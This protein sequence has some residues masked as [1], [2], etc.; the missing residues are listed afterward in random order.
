M[1]IVG[2]C[3]GS[4]SGKTHLLRA[5]KRHFS[6]NQ[7]SL[8]SLD[9]YYKPIAEQ[10]LEP[11]G[12]INFDHP[13]S[14]DLEK[15]A[16]DVNRL[17]NGESFSLQEYT[18]NNHEITPKTFH[19]SPTPI[20][21]V[22]G[23]LVFYHKPLADLMN[24]KIFV[25]ADEHIRLVRRLRRDLKHRNYSYDDTLHDYEHF[26]APMYKQF[27]EPTKYGCD[28]IIMNNH[29]MQAAIEV[30]TNHLDCIHAKHKN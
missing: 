24:L 17:I 7:M 20:I 21:I 18:F 10:K 9:N 26:V 19:Y 11:N 4:A 28:M 29:K 15:C 13:Q 22:E 2:I 27:V 30:I 5:L 12:R 6:G 14:L 3:G 25:E 1:Y 23:I 8:I 16:E